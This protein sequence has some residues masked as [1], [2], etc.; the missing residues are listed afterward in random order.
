MLKFDRSEEKYSETLETALPKLKNLGFG[1]FK[2]DLPGYEV[3]AGFAMVG[4]EAKFVPD[5]AANRKGRKAYIEV[6]KKTQETTK[7]V[8]KWKLLA[9]IAT[10]KN[11]FFGIIAP[12]GTVKFTKELLDEYQI[13]AQLI[14][15]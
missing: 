9:K 11:G 14:R 12:R 13:S 15:I 5:I 6:A 3:P 10:L 4:E 2:A 7:L 8:S 1:D